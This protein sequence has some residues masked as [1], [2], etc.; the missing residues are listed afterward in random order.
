MCRRVVVFFLWA[1]FASVSAM[2]SWYDD[3]DAGL[4]AAR[5]GALSQQAATAINQAKVRIVAAQQ[6]YAQAT[7][8]LNEALTRDAGA[9]SNDDLNAV[10][11]YAE[12]AAS[13]ADLASA[14]GGLVPQQTAIPTTNQSA[15]MASWYDD[16]A[17]GIAAAQA[18]Q[19]SAVIRKMSDAIGDMPKENNKARA[20]GAIFISYH[21]YYY[22][23]VAYLNIG[24]R[25]QAIRDFEK[26]SV[27]GEIDL[28]ALETLMQRAK[29]KP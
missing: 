15:P 26:T 10:I 17:A 14:S 16:Y 27:P 18:G 29:S 4:V 2:A 1:I 25:E 7:Q 6:R 28:G 19:W 21:S 8:A 5:N 22:R 23:G 9:R 11:A 20:F 3:Y 24:K 12:N 13:F